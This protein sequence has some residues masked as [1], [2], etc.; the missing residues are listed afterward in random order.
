MRIVGYLLAV[1]SSA[2]LAG[3]GFP[4]T[5]VGA[6]QGDQRGHPVPICQIFLGHWADACLDAVEIVPQGQLFFDAYIPSP[7]ALE[8]VPESGL[9][10]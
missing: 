4:H 2:K 5:V 3:E 9:G 8:G 6:G 1:G 7:I 10:D